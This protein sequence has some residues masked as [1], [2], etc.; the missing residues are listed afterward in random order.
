MSSPQIVATGRG[1][2]A[3]RIIALA[4][5]HDIPIKEDPE[6]VGLLATLDIGSAIPPE[7]YQAVAE[8]LVFVYRLNAAQAGRRPGA[9]R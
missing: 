8:V 9:S 2:V 7:L 5:E 6:L 1:E 3:E 4:R